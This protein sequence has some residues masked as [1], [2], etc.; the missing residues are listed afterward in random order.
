MKALLFIPVCDKKQSQS[1]QHSYNDES[2]SGLTKRSVFSIV[3]ASV[4]LLRKYQPSQKTVSTPHSLT[5][6]VVN[7]FEL[8]PTVLHTIQWYYIHTRFDAI[9]NDAPLENSI[10]V[11]SKGLKY[12]DSSTL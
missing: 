2:C 12:Y 10:P 1:R 9:S 7:S 11:S 6:N 4:G 3:A 5:D 8:L